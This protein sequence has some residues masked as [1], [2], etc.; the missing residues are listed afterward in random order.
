MNTKSFGAGLAN[1]LIWSFN[2]LTDP[3][4]ESVLDV[5]EFIKESLNK[6]C[7]FVGTKEF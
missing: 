2:D 3:K 6:G 7:D 1:Q 4:T 5:K